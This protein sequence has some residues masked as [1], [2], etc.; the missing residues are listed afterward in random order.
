MA[1][2][3]PEATYK[4]THILSQLGTRS[5]TWGIT[6]HETYGLTADR[7]LRGESSVGGDEGVFLTKYPVHFYVMR[8]GEVRQYVPLSRVTYHAFDPANELAVSIEHEGRNDIPWTP[9]QIDASAKLCAWLC[10][11]YGFP[12]RHATPVEGNKA[13]WAGMFSHGDLTKAHI[14]GSQQNHTD[15]VPNGIG[16]TSFL[17]R[18]QSEMNPPVPVKLT[19]KERLMASWFGGKSADAVIAKIKA[20]YMGDIPNPSDSKLYRALR[21]HGFG[22]AS[23]KRIVKATRKKAA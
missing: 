13:S 16:W 3:Y 8:T 21:D 5:D 18:V 9:P 19:F 10:K 14:G 1:N 15:D 23:A 11:Q 12:V 22:D 2:F 17:Y 6:L 7:Y 4:Q 20:G